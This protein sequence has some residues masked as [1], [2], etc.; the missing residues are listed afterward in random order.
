MRNWL[1]AEKEDLQKDDVDPITP[2]R[3]HTR[4]EQDLLGSETGFSRE[5]FTVTVQWGS[6]KKASKYHSGNQIPE[7]FCRAQ[8]TSHPDLFGKMPV[9]TKQPGIPWCVCI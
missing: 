3:H 6:E 7:V 4:S 2:L 5:D 8:P 9:R 1:P